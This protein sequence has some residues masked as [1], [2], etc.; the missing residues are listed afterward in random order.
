M[1]PS[2]GSSSQNFALARAKVVF[3]HQATTQTSWQAN[4]TNA[5]ILSS[6]CLETFRVPSKVSMQ[7]QSGHLA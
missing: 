3:A 5:E 1:H 6:A 4:L 7:P 2:L